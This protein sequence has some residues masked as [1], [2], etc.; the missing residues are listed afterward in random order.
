M[1]QQTDIND[2]AVQ[3]FA[4]SV[5]V[6][7]EERRHWEQNAF[8]SANDYLYDLLT[9]IYRIYDETCTCDE[10]GKARRE[11]LKQQLAEKDIKCKGKASFMHLLTKLVFSES[12]V[13][14]RRVNTYARVLNIAASTNSVLHFN[15]LKDFI[16]QH[17]G[18]EEIRTSIS[19]S[20][21]NKAIR[22]E[23]ARELA[24]SSE[25]ILQI[26]LTENYGNED[27]EIV[28]LLGVLNK[29]GTCEI[30]HVCK[31][32]NINKKSGGTAIKSVLANFYAS[33]LA[34]TR[35]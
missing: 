6:L 4:H 8:K 21:R 5:E 24:L 11:W 7:I 9:Q 23:K 28:T 13:N 17:G 19:K 12:G 25:S 2:F 35:Q 18:I 27:G 33:K 15:D 31:Q 20:G 10:S 32:E 30:K 22:E 29:D 1:Q 26:G 34:A 16:I 14:S 3:S